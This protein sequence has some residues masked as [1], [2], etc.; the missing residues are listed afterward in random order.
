MLGSFT[1]IN[2]MEE[3]GLQ[4]KPDKLRDRPGQK[5]LDA[6]R[7]RK[8]DVRPDNGDDGDDGTSRPHNPPDKKTACPLRDPQYDSSSTSWGRGTWKRYPNDINL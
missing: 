2:H 3:S 8:R 7:L 6:P 4:R 5:N 1:I